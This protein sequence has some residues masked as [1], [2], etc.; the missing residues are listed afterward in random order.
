MSHVYDHPERAIE[1]GMKA[2]EHAIANLHSAGIAHK[3][4]NFYLS[5]LNSN[6]Q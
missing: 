2:K 6:N 3:T 1:M 4:V 5:I